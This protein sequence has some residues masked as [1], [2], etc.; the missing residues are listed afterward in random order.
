MAPFHF[1]AALLA[2][3]DFDQRQA[4]AVGTLFGGVCN[5]VF[6][7]LGIIALVGAWKVYAKAGKP[8]WASIIP[9]YNFVVLSEIVGRPTWWVILWLIPCTAPFVAIIVAIDLAKS[10]GK[11]V[12]FGIGLAFLWFIFFP[13]LG[14]G[15]AR[16]LGPSVPPPPSPAA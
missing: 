2:Q 9:I 1:A 8:G 14:F 15:D 6:F 13:I 11:G 5:C 10:F 12:G 3:Q 16:Y 4:E 7:I